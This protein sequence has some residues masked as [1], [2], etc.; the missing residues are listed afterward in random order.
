MGLWPGPDSKEITKTLKFGHDGAKSDQN[1]IIDTG[2]FP[3]A[4]NSF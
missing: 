1:C 2:D 3:T 4:K